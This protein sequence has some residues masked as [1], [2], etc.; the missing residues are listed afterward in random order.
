MKTKIFNTIYAMVMLAIIMWF[1]L[2][3]MDVNA[4]NL[5]DAE[6]A[7]WNLFEILYKLSEEGI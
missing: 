3:F 7:P 1:S 4:T 2:S 5:T 6:L